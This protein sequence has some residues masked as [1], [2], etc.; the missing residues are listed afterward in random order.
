MSWI[1]LCRTFELGSTEIKE[2]AG[3]LYTLLSN[4]KKELGD[5]EP[6]CIVAHSLV[7]LARKLAMNS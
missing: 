2:A 3:K 5:D 4:I 7:F 6:I 1:N